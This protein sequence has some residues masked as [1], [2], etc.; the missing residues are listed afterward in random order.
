M[1]TV[2]VEPQP[3]IDT[4]VKLSNGADARSAEYTGT[5]WF[6][7]KPIMSG[8]VLRRA[9]NAPKG[10]RM[11]NFSASFF[12]PDSLPY[13]RAALDDA[14]LSVSMVLRASGETGAIVDAAATFTDD[15]SGAPTWIQIHVQGHLAWP[16][17]VG[18]RVIALTSP[19]AV[20]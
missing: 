20:R 10:I 7:G 9:P 17:A 16:A 4:L 15:P 19:D 13:N 5:A 6:D 12:V 11:P 18:Y 3:R 1:T 8:A 14:T 2:E